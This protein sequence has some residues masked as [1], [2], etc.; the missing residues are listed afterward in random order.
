MKKEMKIVA[1]FAVCVCGGRSAWWWGVGV[2]GW[3][4]AGAAVGCAQ[5]L[6]Q[7]VRLLGAARPRDR[8]GARGGGGVLRMWHRAA[9]EQGLQ[10]AGSC[11]QAR[12]R[13]PTWVV[14]CYYS[15]CKLCP[16]LDGRVSALQLPAELA[17]QPL[18]PHHQHYAALERLRGR[19]RVEVGLG[20]RCSMLHSSTCT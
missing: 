6:A 8:G 5:Q 17:V 1:S 14:C 13:Q 15:K 20:S 2:G 19:M 10:P 7:P 3:Q 11:Y 12:N 16:H 4:R 9:G 18:V